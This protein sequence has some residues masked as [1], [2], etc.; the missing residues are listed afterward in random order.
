MPNMGTALAI[1]VQNA[2]HLLPGQP[3][4][5]AGCLQE[6]SGSMDIRRQ[7]EFWS[8]IRAALVTFPAQARM[9]SNVSV[10]KSAKH[11]I[12]HLCMQL[13]VE[14]EAESVAC[15]TCTSGS[16]AYYACRSFLNWAC[17]HYLLEQGRQSMACS[18][19]ARRCGEVSNSLK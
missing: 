7:A 18:R 17:K 4:W 9:H 15:G 1:L 8:L 10:F 19:H 13:C 3:D 2:Q 6:Q 12:Q 16:A 5:Q 14:N 11:S